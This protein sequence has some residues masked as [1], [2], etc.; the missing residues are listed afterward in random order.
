MI[1]PLGWALGMSGFTSSTDGAD[2][3]NGKTYGRSNA[4]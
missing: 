4:S 1:S 3:P 2:V